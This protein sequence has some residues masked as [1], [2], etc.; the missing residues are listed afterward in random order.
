MQFLL[1][2]NTQRK[3]IMNLVIV[4]VS[5]VTDLHPARPFTS[6]G[7]HERVVETWGRKK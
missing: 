7:E 1:N 5:V 4:E 3:K 6:E 2:M